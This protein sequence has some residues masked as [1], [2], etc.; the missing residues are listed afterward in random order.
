M[1]SELRFDG[2]VVIVTGAGGGLGRA[3]ALLFASRGAQVVVNDLG[4]SATGA[5]QSSSA[6]DRVVEEIRAAGGQAVSSHHSVEDGEAIVK[7]A[8]DAFGRV[9]VVVNNAGILR[10]V[11]FAKM[12]EDDWE[13]VYRVHVLGAFRVTRAAW[14]H[15]RE[16]QYGRVIMTASA[17]GIYGNFGQA[18]YSMAK[19][20]LAGFASTLALEGRSK[21]ILVN[22]IAP[23]AGSRLTETVL[24]AELVAALR[25]EY[26]SPLVAYLAH[27]SSAETGGLF[28][29]G[30]GFF[31][32]LRQERAAGHTVRLGRDITPETVAEAWP[33]ITGFEESTHPTDVMS[34]M[35]PI[36]DNIQA[37][38]SKGGNALIDVDQALGYELPETRSSWDARDVAL[39]ALG[40]GAG[41]DP[42]DDGDLQ[43]VYEL[44]GEGMKA[45][46]T[47][48]VVPA[49]NA[50]LGLA[51]DG[52][53]APGLHYG[54]ERI[55]HGEQTT[56][57]YRP[58][59]T[60][61]RVTHRAR[62][63]DIFDKGKNAL[64]VVEVM[65]RDEAGEPLAKNEIVLLVRGAGGWGGDRGPTGERNVP[66]SRA[67]DAVMEEK[68]A[69]GQALLY[70]LSGDWNPLHVDPGFAQAF[71]FERPILHGLCSLGHAGRHVI[72][73]F[74][75]GADPR[76]V[77]RIDVR[78]TASVFP[79]ETL[80]TEMWRESETRILFRTRVKERDAVALSNGAVELF[81]A[82]PAPKAK[83]KAEAAA[84]AAPE[85]QVVP[86]T[87]D[88]FTAI[89]G[90]IAERPEMVKKVATVFQFKLTQPD[91]TYTVDLKEAPPSVR[92]GEPKPADCTLELSDADFL[93]M[94]TGA[95]DP[96]KL[97]FAGKMKISGNVMAAQKL[98]FLK[99]VEPER[100]FAAAGA[101][102]GQPEARAPE[103]KAPDA[104]APEAASAPAAVESRAPAFFAA[105]EAALAA[106]PAWA[107]EVSAVLR[108]QLT[109]P[110]GAWTLDLRQTP[111]TARRDVEG[112]ADTT[113][114][115][116]EADLFALAR[117]EV[118][119][120]RLFQQGKLRVDGDVRLAH[121]LGF[122][123][124]AAGKEAR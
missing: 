93:A 8:L 14:P 13:K 78:M 108:L 41:R 84:A 101:R 40:V 37:G 91:A 17:A 3:H 96:Q 95:A 107:A 110:A 34:A 32:K 68:V 73:R 113:L 105:L 112:A 15:M 63:K 31:A 81:E 120:Q 85:V 118:S 36:L 58:L 67:P 53:T 79:G 75:P 121:R 97:Y 114:T 117:G 70:R 38:P 48:A 55:L 90:Y 71:G 52:I 87:A 98:E 23:L 49:V 20:G 25:P 28:E 21:N 62:I 47:F 66:P 86:T 43:L 7:T 16:Q 2:R 69:E 82:L 19:L 44:H 54:L 77:R 24:P 60:E 88:I 50:F 119:A 64:V 10:D 6:A 56:E 89:G 72:R 42:A 22:T 94:C 51:R 80:V 11:T 61:A 102:S 74:A 111:G 109:E 124:L 123:R 9:D 29:V 59:P 18:N 115:L 45:L 106:H 39:Y 100:V 35:Q 57:L 4:G 122:L 33:K 1:T 30:G 83:V 26:V 103:A 92:P 12:T 5:G 46:P 116:A 104:K 76:F 65:T 99:K 27:E